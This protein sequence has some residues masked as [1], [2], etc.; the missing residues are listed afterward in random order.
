MVMII[1]WIAVILATLSTQVAAHSGGLNKRGCHAGSEPYHCHRSPSA[2]PE[3]S[4]DPTILRGKLTHVRDGDT[5]EVNG[6]AVRLSALD[7]PENDTVQGQIV[8]KLAK[9]FVGLQATCELT[10]AR[11][12]DRVVG[13]CSVGG[14]DFGSYMMQNSS[15]KFWPKYD[16]WS[17]Y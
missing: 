7:C 6:I 4:S 14:S 11:S 3:A 12:Y 10:G 1:V 2:A 16:V 8:S 5:I 9:Q 17:R 13:Y 15:C